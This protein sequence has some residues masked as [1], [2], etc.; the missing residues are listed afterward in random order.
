MATDKT[1]RAPIF[2]HG[3]LGRSGTNYLTEM[4]ALHPA[5]AVS[6]I[7]EDWLLAKSEC[8]TE[9]EAE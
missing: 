3:I 4:L 8:L 2:V 9:K 1:T 6:R 7:P 5:C